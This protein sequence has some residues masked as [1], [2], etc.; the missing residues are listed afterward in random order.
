MQS[1]L[2]KKTSVHLLECFTPTVAEQSENGQGMH[3][4]SPTYHNTLYAVEPELVEGVT[5]CC[6]WRTGTTC[7]FIPL[8]VRHDNSV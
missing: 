8:L 2:D 3:T 1:I 5:D 6:E 7:R 4:V